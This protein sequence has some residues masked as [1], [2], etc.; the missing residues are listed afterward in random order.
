MT[1]GFSYYRSMGVSAEQNR[2]LATTKLPM[3]VLVV[4]GEAGVGARMIDAVVPLCE[5]ARGVLLDGC[6]HY[7]PEEAPDRL[8]VLLEE[9]LEGG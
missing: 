9:F 1:S 4:A 5:N 2:A 7:I 8:A 3:P 6:G